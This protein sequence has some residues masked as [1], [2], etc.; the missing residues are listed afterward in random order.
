[1]LSFG[2]VNTTLNSTTSSY[3]LDSAYFES[4]NNSTDSQ[5]IL[6]QPNT[7]GLGLPETSFDQVINLLQR[8]DGF[9][10]MKYDSNTR[11]Y[12]LDSGCSSFA[13]WN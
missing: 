7:I 6:I 2:H 1:M 11:R 12:Y 4:I 5:D 8:I 3:E 10:Y 13:G 9:P